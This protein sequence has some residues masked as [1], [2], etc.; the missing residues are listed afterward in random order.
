MEVFKHWECCGG[1]FILF[2]FLNSETKVLKY[3]LVNCH[4]P[5]VI[6]L[7]ILIMSNDQVVT[8]FQQSKK[9]EISSQQSS[10]PFFK[11]GTVFFVNFK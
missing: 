2:S 9:I 3:I 5:Y 11:K 8:G 7:D 1:N 4:H 10:V 6:I